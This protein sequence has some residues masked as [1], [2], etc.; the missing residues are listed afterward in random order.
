M[1]EDSF[2]SMNTK[3]LPGMAVMA[4]S[5]VVGFVPLVIMRWLDHNDQTP[6]L[7]AMAELKVQVASLS[8]RVKTLT[9]QPYVRRDEFE[10][11]LSGFDRRI[12]EIERAAKPSR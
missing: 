3:A 11:R 12:G 6:T 9:E 2:E 8:E 1:E 7:V 5:I 4:V 10:E